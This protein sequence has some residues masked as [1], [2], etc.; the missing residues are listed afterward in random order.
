MREGNKIWKIKGKCIIWGTDLKS[1]IKEITGSPPISGNSKYEFDSPRA[2]GKYHVSFHICSFGQCDK[3]YT[4]SKIKEHRELNNT[5]KIRL[6]GYIA[7]QN[8]LGKT[9]LLD[10]IV[11][12]ENSLKILPL[13]PDNLDK[14]SDLLLKGLAKQYP[15]K[16]ETIRGLNLDSNLQGNFIPFLC[17]LSYCSSSKDFEFLLFDHLK[18]ELKYVATERIYIT[19]ARDIKITSKGWKRLNKIENKTPSEK[20][21]TAFIAMWIDPSMEDLKQSIEKAVRNTGYNPLRID[22]KEHINKICEEILSEINKSK[23]VICDLTSK[24][25][26]PRGSVYFEAGYAKGKNIPIIWSCNKKLEKDIP[27]DIRQYNFI[28]WEDDKMNDFT[29]KLQKRIKK[30]IGLGPLK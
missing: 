16:G 18:D 24:K 5:E 13:P 20:S 30:V 7:E 17:A 12:D 14:Q 27:F 26:K 22:N 19:G 9:P 8:L 1:A 29:E 15:N 3:V 6:S 21:E 10:P 4:Y 2:G 25:E 28:F 11:K 23:F